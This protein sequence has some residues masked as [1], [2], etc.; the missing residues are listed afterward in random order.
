MRFK[1]PGSAP[2]HLEVR[3]RVRVRRRP[4]VSEHHAPVHLEVLCL[5]DDLVFGAR[6]GG[7]PRA[8]T[9]CAMHARRRCTLHAH[10]MCMCIYVCSVAV[11]GALAAE[12]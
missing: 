7:L 5:V 3:V 8:R 12:P 11:P 2:V 9:K 6:I 10:C 1:A 4:R